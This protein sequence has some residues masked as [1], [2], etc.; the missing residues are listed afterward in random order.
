M[1]DSLVSV[2]VPVYNGGTELNRC[3]DSILNQTYQKIELILID[4]GST[5]ASLEVCREYAAK[6]ERVRVLHQKN[7]GVAVARN[8]GLKEAKGEYISFVDASDYV[9][10]D[11]IE[12]LYRACSYNHCNLSMCN[13]AEVRGEKIEKTDVLTKDGI[14]SSAELLGD[15]LYGRDIEGFC[16]G[17]IWKKDF[18]RHEFQKFRY[19]EDILFFVENFSHANERIA[20]VKKTMYYYVKQE[21]SVTSKRRAI[22]L[23]HTLDV[24]S[25]IAKESKSSPVIKQKE[26]YALALN[27]AFFAFLSVKEDDPHAAQLKKRCLK[28]IKRLRGYVFWDY[29]SSIKTKGACFLSL[30]SEGII[31]KVYSL[32]NSGR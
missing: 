17:K 28:W 7:C 9:E 30:F 14:I 19:C 13:Y 26:A 32:I 16:W 21:G 15:I 18:I 10:P 6:D 3:I 11:Y 23:K 31:R 22:D 29:E 27:Y 2:I 25:L 4:D 12:K 5:D 24:A 1:K 20:T 8:R